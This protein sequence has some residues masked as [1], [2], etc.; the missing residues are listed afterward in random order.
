MV[1]REPSLI[2]L[3]T[4]EEVDFSEASRTRVVD[5][6]GE[7]DGRGT[8]PSAISEPGALIQAHP[9]GHLERRHGRG[10]QIA[11]PEFV[12]HHLIGRAATSESGREAIEDGKKARAASP[13]CAPMEFAQDVEAFQDCPGPGSA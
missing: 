1:P 4:P 9:A 2:G 5:D 8:P 7:Q 10:H 11:V 12:D 13:H 6:G 3:V